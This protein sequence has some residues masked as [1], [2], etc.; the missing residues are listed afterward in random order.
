MKTT[1]LALLSS[2]LICAVIA[3]GTPST[4]EAERPSVLRDGAPVGWAVGSGPGD[5]LTITHFPDRG[6]AMNFGV[7]Y[8][9][10]AA[11]TVV[12]ATGFVPNV[13]A[14]LTIGNIVLGLHTE[15]GLIHINPDGPFNPDINIGIVGLLPFF[16]YWFGGEDFAPFIGAQVGPTFTIPDGADTSVLFIAGGLG[17][18]HFFVGDSFSIGPTA[19]FNFAYTSVSERAGYEFTLGFSMRGWGGGVS[20]SR[21]GGGGG[22]GTTSPEAG[23][24]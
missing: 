3:F 1:R 12:G 17:G 5:L 14:A 7:F 2:A 6:F 18:L 13:H 4:V 19:Q 9:N 22:G 15:F 20:S 23:A 21:G 24:N 11:T 16:E 10:V 8:G